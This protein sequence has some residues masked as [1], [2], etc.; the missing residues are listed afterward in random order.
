MAKKSKNSTSVNSTACKAQRKARA[1]EIADDFVASTL[2]D[3]NVAAIQVIDEYLMQLCLSAPTLDSQGIS[4]E[5]FAVSTTCF[6]NLRYCLSLQGHTAVRTARALEAFWTQDAFPDT[7]SHEQYVVVAGQEELWKDCQ[8]TVQDAIAMNMIIYPEM[9]E[10]VM[11]MMGLDITIRSRLLHAYHIQKRYFRDVGASLVN[12][13]GDRMQEETAVAAPG[14]AGSSTDGILG[15]PPGLS[16]PTPAQALLEEALVELRSVLVNLSGK[17]GFRARDEAKSV[18]HSCTARWRRKVAQ[19]APGGA[20]FSATVW[21][22]SVAEP[23]EERHVWVDWNDTKLTK[24][25]TIQDRTLIVAILFNVSPILGVLTGRDQD[26]NSAIYSA[27]KEYVSINVPSTTEM[28]DLVLGVLQAEPSY[29]NISGYSAYVGFLG[30]L[31]AGTA[32][33]EHEQW[34]QKTGMCFDMSESLFSTAIHKMVGTARWRHRKHWNYAEQADFLC[35]VLVALNRIFEGAASLGAAENEICDLATLFIVNYSPE[36]T[37]L[38]EARTLLSLAGRG[39]TH[40]WRYC[41]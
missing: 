31:L 37:A 20:D 30:H 14:G 13:G 22:H 38:N 3:V 9:F 5:Y 10:Q 24:N 34:A 27:L 7:F 18:L 16:P 35:E 26:D 8:R 21:I 39:I 40:N 41:S 4:S 15:V 11:G 23:Q 33:V 36:P 12:I 28:Q 32:V 1:S 6:N 2:D 17:A 29:Y 25:K 19:Q